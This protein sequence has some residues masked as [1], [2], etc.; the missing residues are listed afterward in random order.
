MPPTRKA[1]HEHEL[2]DRCGYGGKHTV[3]QKLPTAKRSDRKK[4]AKNGEKKEGDRERGGGN[5]NGE[6]DGRKVI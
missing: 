3:K 4:G 1:T 2:V 6:R 5:G